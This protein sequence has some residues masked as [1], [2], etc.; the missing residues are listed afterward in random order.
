MCASSNNSNINRDNVFL[1]TAAPNTAAKPAIDN[2]TD[3]ITS[4]RSSSSF[5]STSVLMEAQV[6]N[7]MKPSMLTIHQVEKDDSDGELSS[8]NDWLTAWNS[9]WV[10]VQ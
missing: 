7:S 10:F 8:M 6:E 5:V 2:Q 1:E 9:I 4:S 3:K